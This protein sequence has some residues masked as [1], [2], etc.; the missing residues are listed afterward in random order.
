MK[1]NGLG[2][3]TGSCV[4][5]GCVCCVCVCA[6][7]RLAVNN[8]LVMLNDST[9]SLKDKGTC[10]LQLA[11]IKVLATCHR[12]RSTDLHA[13]CLTLPW[14]DLVCSYNYK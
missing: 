3:V 8:Q 10:I 2:T 12:R 11:Y 7:S 6:R 1:L 9:R 13:E 4:D 14:L 5:V